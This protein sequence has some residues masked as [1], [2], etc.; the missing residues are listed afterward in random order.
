MVIIVQKAKEADIQRLLDIM[1]AAFSTNPWNRIMYPEIP[2]P[3]A[4]GASFERWRDEI[5][6]N[7]TIRFMKAVDTE[8]QEIIAFAR[9]NIHE[10]E[11]PESEWKSIK[12][13][14]WDNGT[15]VEAANEFY[16]AVCGARQKFMGGKPH[17]C[18]FEST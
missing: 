14:N 2:G 8:L 9:W 1:Y 6:T 11:R 7:P 3:E 18:K 13:R 16:N 15:N 10:V 12:P 4:R 17:C 5:L